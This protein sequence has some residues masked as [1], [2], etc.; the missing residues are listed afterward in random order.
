MQWKSS[1]KT[2]KRNE[3][4]YK[5]IDNYD[6]FEEDLQK[7]N[8]EDNNKNK[9]NLNYFDTIGEKFKKSNKQ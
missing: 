2:V 4:G 3:S 1:P 6:F 5:N 7:E 9:S 8:Q